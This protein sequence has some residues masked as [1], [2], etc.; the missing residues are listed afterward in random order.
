[1]LKYYELPALQDHEINKHQM[2]GVREFRTAIAVHSMWANY[3]AVLRQT[4]AEDFVERSFG[5]DHGNR[6]YQFP[7]PDNIHNIPHSSA[8]HGPYSAQL[9]GHRDGRTP[10]SHKGMLRMESSQPCNWFTGRPRLPVFVQ[11]SNTV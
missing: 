10:C 3:L 7:K 5:S 4:F 2:Y 8:A 1:M 9:G 6:H 11:L